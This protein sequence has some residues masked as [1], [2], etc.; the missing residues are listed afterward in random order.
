MRTSGTRAMT[1]GIRRDH[2]ATTTRSAAG[3]S[4]DSS[5]SGALSGSGADARRAALPLPSGLSFSLDSFMKKPPPPFTQIVVVVP[6]AD[7][8][9]REIDVYASL[10]A[11]R[12]RAPTPARPRR[13]RGR[14]G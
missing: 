11:P 6:G 5:G 8:Y 7:L 14:A 13:R 3:D 12:P 10:L 9:P 2:S 4:S 1:G